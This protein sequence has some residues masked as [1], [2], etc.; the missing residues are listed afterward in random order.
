MNF[1]KLSI[2]LATGAALGAASA[3]PPTNPSDP[4]SQQV[5]QRPGSASSPSKG[6]KRVSKRSS[7]SAPPVGDVTNEEVS[8][9]PGAASTPT[10]S[11]KKP[12]RKT[13]SP[14]LLTSPDDPDN[15]NV[16]SHGEAASRP[17]R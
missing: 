9:H 2:A 7:D 14:P 11:S 15:A 3:Q 16:Q 6:V 1:A 5:A 13:I 17:K 12:P 8:Q 10:R 4:T